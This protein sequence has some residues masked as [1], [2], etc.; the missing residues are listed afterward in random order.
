MGFWEFLDKY[1]FALTTLIGTLGGTIIG[2]YVSRRNQKD[3][4]MEQQKTEI[5]QRKQERYYKKIKIYNKFL[6]VDGLN[7]VA[8]TVENQVFRYKI[9][10]EEIRP[11]FYE[12]LSCLDSDIID[13]IMEIDKELN[14]RY[15]IGEEPTFSENQ[16]ISDTYY[17]M[18]KAIRDYVKSD[19]GMRSGIK[20]A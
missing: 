12:D 20:N 3:I 13:L 8:G 4:F 14:F 9:Y 1:F 5:R 18:F 15:F 17:E 11:V 2:S 16:K 10:R 7:A 6:E 19:D